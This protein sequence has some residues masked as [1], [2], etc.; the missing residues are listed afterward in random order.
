MMMEVNFFCIRQYFV[1]LQI[2]VVINFEHQISVFSFNLIVAVVNG[3]YI[4]C[5]SGWIQ[6]HTCLLHIFVTFPCVIEEPG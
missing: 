2:S 6:F 4:I 5:G 1:E 3:S